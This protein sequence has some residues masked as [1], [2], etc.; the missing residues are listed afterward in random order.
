MTPTEKLS[1]FQAEVEHLRKIHFGYIAP[2]EYLDYVPAKAKFHL[3]LAHLLP[4]PTYAEFYK[5]RQ[6]QGDM[7]FMDNSAFEFGGSIEE[8]KLLELIEAGGFT[9]DV[10]VAPDYP[11]QKASKTL[12]STRKFIKT[13]ER[14]GIDSLVMGVPQSVIGNWN[15]WIDAFDQMQDITPVIGLSILGIPNAAQSQTGTKDISYNRLWAMDQLKSADGW[16]SD[17]IWYHA[18]GAGSPSEFRLQASRTRSLYGYDF[19]GSVAIHSLDTS[20]PIWHGILG[21]KYDDSATGLIKGKSPK[22]V[23][24]DIKRATG[25]KLE[26][27]KECILHNIKYVEA[28]LN[29]KPS[30]TYI[31]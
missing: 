2:I 12:N 10:I 14:E 5:K 13:L 19:N 7:I 9:P 21:I 25:D 24:F 3:C 29:N 18:L 6:A 4:N 28:A 22:H 8:D 11:G 30:P 20:S 23:N 27:Q 16:G 1:S 15:G 26:K 31:K 17:G